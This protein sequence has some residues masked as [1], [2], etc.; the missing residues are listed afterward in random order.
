MVHPPGP[1]RCSAAAAAAALHIG[2][3]CPWRTRHRRRLRTLLPKKGVLHSALALLTAMRT[4]RPHASPE[5][6]CAAHA[7]RCRH[8][9]FFIQR[10]HIFPRSPPPRRGSFV[11]DDEASMDSGYDILGGAAAAAD[12]LRMHLPGAMRSAAAAQGPPRTPQ[13]APSIP[14]PIPL[15][16][17][18]SKDHMFPISVAQ[19]SLVEQFP[20][21]DP[22]LVPY[23]TEGA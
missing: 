21:L 20:G 3:T 23:L 9:Q 12:P 22:E 4:C 6:C 14:A 18:S 8:Q 15:M 17:L 5:H 11:T 2:L 16:R 7:K 1:Q 19:A 13:G 10:S